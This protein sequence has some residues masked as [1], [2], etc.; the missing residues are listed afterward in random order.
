L[1]SDNSLSQEIA[2]QILLPVTTAAMAVAAMFALPSA[3]ESLLV[4]AVVSG[5]VVDVERVGHVRLL[6]IEIPSVVADAAR[7][8]LASLV[9]RRWVRLEYADENG[10]SSTRRAAFVITGDAVCVNTVLVREGLA[11]VSGR[12]PPARLDEL[13]NAEAE[14]RRLEKGMWGYTRP[15]Q[16]QKR[17]SSWPRSQSSTHRIGKFGNATSFITASTTG[18]SGFSFS[19]SRRAR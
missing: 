15:P 12:V 11:R 14:A 13:R 2:M 3:A 7:E 6:G 19:S 18:R 8:R 5:G 4:R 16:P 10:S 1:F 17:R 9:L